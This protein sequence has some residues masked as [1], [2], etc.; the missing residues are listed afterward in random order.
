MVTLTK[1]D[2]VDHLVSRL[3][4]TRPQG[5]LIV[6]ACFEE[7]CAS[8]IEGQDI[9]ISGFGNFMLKDKGSRPGRN[10]KTG[11][12]VQVTAR[13]VVTFKASQKLRHQVDLAQEQ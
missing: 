11:E 3:G 8:L 1:A 7:I 9:K 10:P 6:N 13:R 5:R 2:I 12:E 4:F